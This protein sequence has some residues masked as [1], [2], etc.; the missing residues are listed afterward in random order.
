MDVAATH[1]QTS[2]VAD[3]LVSLEKPH[4]DEY[5]TRQFDG[6][7][8]EARILYNKN[9]DLPWLL[10]IHGARADYSKANPISFGLQDRGISSLGV[11]M[12]GHS[13]TSPL[14]PEETSLGN[15]IREVRAFFDDLDPAKPAVVMAFS[16]G[17]TPALK[18]LEKYADRISKLVLFYPGIY[19]KESYDKHY[20][21]PFRA[22]ISQPY[23]YLHNDTIPL[24][25]K[26][27]GKLLLIK[28][29]YDGLD[30]VDY[31]KPAGTSAGQ[32]EIDGKTYYSPI[33]KEVIELI[34]D[35]VPE[36]R[37]TIIEVPKSDHTVIAWMREHPTEAQ[38]ILDQLAAFIAE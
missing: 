25:Q 27:K 23:S 16:L 15:N 12:S 1:S 28:G 35:V 9:H 7:S 31:G 10:S 24:L 13:A 3:K 2:N 34:K 11:N 14:L 37:R 4:D 21:E 6:Y 32:V 33:P 17:G 8:L 36:A 26:F 38:K 22:V 30:P 5:V 29:E 20:G 18:L 19:A